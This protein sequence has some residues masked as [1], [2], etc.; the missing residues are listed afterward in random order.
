MIESRS[1]VGV[2]HYFR[3]FSIEKV[4]AFAD[5]M[6]VETCHKTHMLNVVLNRECIIE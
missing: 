6:N 2:Y 3:G 5:T 1:H 4:S